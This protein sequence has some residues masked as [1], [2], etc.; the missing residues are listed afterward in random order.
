LS[1][2]GDFPSAFFAEMKASIAERTVKVGR[3]LNKLERFLTAA[4]QAKIE[5][6]AP[7]VSAEV[8]TPAAPT[9]AEDPAESELAAGETIEA[10]EIGPDVAAPTDERR[11]RKSGWLWAAVAAAIIVGAAAWFTVGVESERPVDRAV[12][13]APPAPVIESNEAPASQNVAQH[14]GVAVVPD[15]QLPAEDPAAMRV[16]G[17]VESAHGDPRLITELM[18]DL[19]LG[20]GMVRVDSQVKYAKVAAGAAEVYLRPQSRPD[21]RER[22]W[23]HVAGVVVTE[24]AGGRVTDVRGHEL[25][26]SL[27][28]RLTENR[29]VLATN[30][31][32]H[33]RLLATLERLGA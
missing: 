12:E 1:V 19:K 6:E 23:D 28:R 31:P 26:F 17:S 4:E 22:I 14:A 30:G 32:L 27:G 7:V 25:D 15:V 2:R 10:A 5:S 29:G 8:D 18:R 33:D 13:P 21:Y 11:R 3:V 24:A 20:G 9:I 16:L